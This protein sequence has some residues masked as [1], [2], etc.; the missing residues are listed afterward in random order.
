MKIYIVRHYDAG[1]DTSHRRMFVERRN[2]WA[3]YIETITRFGFEPDEA[4]PGFDLEF[5][6]DFGSIVEIYEQETED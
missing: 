4:D 1:R 6:L 3:A 2:A 5:D